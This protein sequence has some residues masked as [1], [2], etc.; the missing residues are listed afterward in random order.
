MSNKPVLLLDLDDTL[1]NKKLHLRTFATFFANQV[2]T[3]QDVVRQKISDYIESLPQSN[4]FS[5]STLVEILA[6]AYSVNS[7]WVLNSITE[8][9]L[10]SSCL[11]PEVKTALHLLQEEYSLGL[12]SEGVV[13]SQLLKIEASGILNFFKKDLCFICSDKRSPGY[14]R[15]VPESIILDDKP[16]II[17]T[18]EAH[19]HITPIWINRNGARHVLK[20]RTITSLLDLVE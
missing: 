3:N 14:L 15:T 13:Q 2:R 6:E 10:F 16:K 7:A 11:F 4:Q 18:L 8:G 5:Y 17:S 19:N 12:Y 9:Q 20:S 1:L